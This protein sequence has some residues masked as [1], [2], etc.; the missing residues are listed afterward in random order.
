MDID[1]DGTGARHAPG[2][3][4]TSP[5]GSQPARSHTH[6]GHEERVKAKPATRVPPKLA[7]KRG[8]RI[9]PGPPVGTKCRAAAPAALG[10]PAHSRRRGGEVNLDLGV[11]LPRGGG[12][13]A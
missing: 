13:S 10:R 8:P 2:V 3:P 4:T 9:A 5:K 7:C 1:T 11:V 12:W 6:T